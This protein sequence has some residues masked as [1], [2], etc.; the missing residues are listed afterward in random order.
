MVLTREPGGTALGEALRG[1][2]LREP[3]VSLRA[4][5]LLFLAARAQHVEEV[6]APAL[7]QGKVVLCDRFLDSTVAYQGYGRKLGA[8]WVEQLARLAVPLLPRGTLLLD[9]DPEQGLRRLRRERDRLEREEIAFHR[10]VREGFLARAAREPER[11]VVLDASQL[12]EHVEAE[13]WEVI[14]RRWI[15]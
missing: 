15:D 9:L 13:A 10:A 4:E 7:A 11:I 2:L 6:I 3:A 12:Q 14:E 1:F 8:E 5:L